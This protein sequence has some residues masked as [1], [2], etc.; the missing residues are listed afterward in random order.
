MLLIKTRLW[1]DLICIYQKSQNRLT[2][3]QK[4]QNRC[5]VKTCIS[6]YHNLFY[7]YEPEIAIEFCQNRY[8][9]A[10]FFLLFNYPNVKDILISFF[11]RYVFVFLDPFY[12]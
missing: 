9:R 6:F 4:T 8:N 5:R 12:V 3:Y 10:I 1:L 2:I 11:D 7:L